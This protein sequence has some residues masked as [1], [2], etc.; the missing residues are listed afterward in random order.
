M[1]S[2]RNNKPG[3]AFCFAA[4]AV[5]RPR[6]LFSSNKAARRVRENRAL[7]GINEG[8][9]VAGS[10]ESFLEGCP[11]AEFAIQ[12]RRRDATLDPGRSI[13]IIIIGWSLSFLFAVREAGPG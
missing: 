4:T 7:F 11:W 5:T 6:Y 3:E 1:F 13:S 12:C 9:K 8:K 2:E 10:M